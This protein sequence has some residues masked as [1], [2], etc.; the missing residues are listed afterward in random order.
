MMRHTVLGLAF[1]ASAASASA[2][3]LLVTSLLSDEVLR[4]NATTGAFIGTLVSAGSGGLDGPQGIAIGTDGVMYVASEYSGSIHKYDAATGAPL[5]VLASGLPAPN[6]LTF[7]PGGLLY[8][9]D[10]GADRVRRFNTSLGTELAPIMLA[11]G[12]HHAHGITVGPDGMIYIGILDGGPGRIRKLNPTTLADLGNFVTIPG[13][14]GIFDL[15]FLPD[16]SLV[17]NDSFAGAIYRYHGV[18]GAPLVPLAAPG[19]ISS[20]F[21]MA[22]GPDGLLYVCSGGLGVQ[23]YDPVTGASL[24]GFISGGAGS[25]FAPAWF[26]VPS[27]GAASIVILLVGAAGFRRSRD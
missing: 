2:R 7:G 12:S 24:G 9:M 6:D 25:P 16:G 5:G 3:D 23:R 26:T 18:T 4:Y 20:P 17:V 8:Y 22:M 19:T 11:D 27:P 10:H 13:T 21:G 15:A 1:L 14:I